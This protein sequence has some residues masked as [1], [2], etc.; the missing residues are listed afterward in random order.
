[1]T[2]ATFVRLTNKHSVAHKY[3]SSGGH[4]V[5][6]LCRVDSSSSDHLVAQL[7]YSLDYESEIYRTRTPMCLSGCLLGEKADYRR[8]GPDKGVRTKLRQTI[9]IGRLVSEPTSLFGG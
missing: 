6:S 8:I 5:N 1:M 9:Y 7:S 4:F 2:P 3:A